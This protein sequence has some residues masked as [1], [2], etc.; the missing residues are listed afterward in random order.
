[1]TY[2]AEGIDMIFALNKRK[3]G[4]LDDRELI[5]EIKRA[6]VLVDKAAEEGIV[7]SWLGRFGG[8]IERHRGIEPIPG[9]PTDPPRSDD[10]KA[11]GG[12]I[13]QE[14]VNLGARTPERD[15]EHARLILEQADRYLTLTQGTK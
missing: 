2:H 6:C 14:M 12:W 11:I 4:T 15:A 13:I 3:K 10:A 5:V 1:V 9:L 7:S 8:A